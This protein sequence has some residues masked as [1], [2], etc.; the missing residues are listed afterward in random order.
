MGDMYDVLHTASSF[1]GQFGWSRHILVYRRTD[2]GTLKV[3]CFNATEIDRECTYT[4]S[5][6]RTWEPLSRLTKFI[7][8]MAETCH[9]KMTAP[10]TPTSDTT[11]RRKT[12]WLVPYAGATSIPCSGVGSLFG[13]KMLVR[14]I[15]LTDILDSQRHADRIQEYSV[16]LL[17]AANI[18]NANMTNK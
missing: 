15:P 14:W 2:A 10:R 18:L 16:A 4:Q 17:T 7:I 12:I 8:N 6:L 1:G 11:R 9:K 5:D 3:L 13:G